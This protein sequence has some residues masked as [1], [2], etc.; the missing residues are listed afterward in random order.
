MASHWFEER[1]R[2]NLMTWQSR[3]CWNANLIFDNP[4]IWKMLTSRSTLLRYYHC[5]ISCLL[6]SLGTRGLCREHRSLV[7]C[8]GISHGAVLSF[9]HSLFLSLR[10]F[11]S[12][13][14]LVSLRQ[15]SFL[16]PLFPR[17]AK[18]LATHHVP[19]MGT[20][21]LSGFWPCSASRT[22]LEMGCDDDCPKW[23]QLTHIL[24]FLP[25]LAIAIRF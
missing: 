4:C 17:Y 14:A 11:I 19:R 9:C 5:D 24:S 22:N 15:P 7:R 20:I 18:S 2:C 3:D 16:T 10:L 12:S 6:R 8:N 21:R 1:R 13:P 25:H 23:L